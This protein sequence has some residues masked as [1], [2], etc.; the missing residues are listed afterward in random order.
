[1]SPALHHSGLLQLADG[2]CGQTLPQRLQPGAA[3]FALLHVNAQTGTPRCPSMSAMSPQ[4]AS[5][6]PLRRRTSLLLATALT[7]LATGCA[8]HPQRPVYSP[9]GR[10]AAPVVVSPEPLVFYP[11]QGQSTGLQDRDRY[12]CYR[13]ASS[14]TNTDPGLAPTRLPPPPGPAPD[15]RDGSQVAAGAVT[16]AVLGAAVSSP[17]RAG[18]HAAAGAVVGMLLGAVAQESRAQA[19]ERAQAGRE[20][21]YQ[22]AA[23]AARAPSDHFRRAMS[24]CMASRGYRVA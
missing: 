16:G 10:S 1:M 6:S 22:Q 24:A 21:R 20:E 17:R 23:A 8:V 5:P 19:V 13:W 7:A 14:Q 4:S 15:V 18:D 12:E 2:P 11:E 9:Y 3:N